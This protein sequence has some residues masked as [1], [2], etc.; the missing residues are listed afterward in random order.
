GETFYWSFDPQGVG[1]LPEDTAEE[2]GLPDIHFHAFVDGKFWTRDHYNIIRQ[3][4]LAKGFD[5][6]SQD[7]AI[8]LGYPLVDV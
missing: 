5:P 1:R 7:V 2:L 6:T 4:H 8:E 3:F